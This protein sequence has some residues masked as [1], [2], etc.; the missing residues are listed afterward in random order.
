MEWHTSQARILVAEDN[1][2]NQMLLEKQLE[3]LGVD[4]DFADNGAIAWESLQ[5]GSYALLLSD[6][7]DAVDGWLRTD[8]S[9]S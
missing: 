5:T 4:A 6:I 3:M 9:N 1:E 8:Q 7:S 2:I